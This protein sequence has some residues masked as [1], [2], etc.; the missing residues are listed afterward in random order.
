MHT[1]IKNMVRKNVFIT[2]QKK[3][4]KQADVLS[5]EK[6]NNLISK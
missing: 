5:V 2:K 1:K 3:E 4:K 6:K